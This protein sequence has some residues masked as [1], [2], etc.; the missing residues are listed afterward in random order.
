MLTSEGCAS[1][2][3]RLWESLPEACDALIVTAPESL[4][5][6]ANYAP[7]PFVFNTVESAA[8]LVMLP[9]SFD[10][11][12]GQPAAAIPRSKPRRTR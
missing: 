12:R 9:R 3:K 10:P 7:S 5:Y 11:V 6:L 4:I 8:A 1:R 2:R